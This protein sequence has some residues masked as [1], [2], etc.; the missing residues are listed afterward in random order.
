MLSK[1][2]VSSR[3]LKWMKENDYT[4]AE[5]VEKTGILQ[6]VTSELMT[7]KAYPSA[8]TIQKVAVN[9][10]LDIYYWLCNG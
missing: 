10:D 2:K 4:Q 1:K 9:T 8:Q 6:S 3:L 5:F 7:G